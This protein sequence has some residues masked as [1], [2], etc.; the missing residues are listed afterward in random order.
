MLPVLPKTCP[1][2]TE[3]LPISYQNLIEILPKFTKIFPKC[4][5]NVAHAIKITTVSRDKHHKL[6]PTSA[7]FEQEGEINDDYNRQ[8]TTM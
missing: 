3:I 8:K 5:K 1:N 7:S 2:L 6:M 4:Y